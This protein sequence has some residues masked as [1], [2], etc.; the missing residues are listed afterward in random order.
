MYS[1]FSG[2][3]NVGLKYSNVII[4][5]VDYGVY[6]VTAPTAA[7][8]LTLTSSLLDSTSG[9]FTIEYFIKN[10]IDDIQYDGPGKTILRIHD[11]TTNILNLSLSNQGVNRLQ[12]YTGTNIN[13]YSTQKKDFLGGTSNTS[14]WNHVAFVY[15]GDNSG[16]N[17][18]YINGTHCLNIVDYPTTNAYTY[19]NAITNTANIGYRMPVELTNARS[20]WLLTD[21]TNSVGAPI[22][23]LRIT[24]GAVYTSGNSNFTAPSTELSETFPSGS[25]LE[26]IFCLESYKENNITYIRDKVSGTSFT[27]YLGLN[28]TARRF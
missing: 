19:V 3:M 20:L 12:M 7:N 11:A 25:G 2:L 8:V 10:P 4:P 16:N 24:R 22:Y 17:H 1:S 13:R 6:T 26:C 18:L 21:L 28:T 5:R 14:R 15:A 9:S 27:S 23:N